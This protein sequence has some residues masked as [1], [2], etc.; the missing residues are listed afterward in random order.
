LTP[1]F[2]NM[3]K[4]VL[5]NQAGFL[6][7]AV[8]TFF[9]S[10]FVV[11][12]LG[13][14]RYGIWSL[15]V[16]LT[17]N[18]GLLAFGIQGAMTR[19]MAHAV[20]SG[21]RLRVNGYF[22]TSL[23]FLAV[24]SLLAVIVG[25]SVALFIDRVFVLPY[26]L[27]A[28]ARCACALATVSA[29]ATFLQAP[30]ESVLVAHQRF[31]V[32]NAIGVVIIMVRAALT[33]WLLKVGYGIVALALVGAGLTAASACMSAAIA[34]ASYRWLLLSLGSVRRVYLT[35]LMSYGG[36]SFVVAVAV[37]LVYQCDLF[38]IGANLPPVSITTYTLAATLFGYLIQ[39]VSAVMRTFTPHTTGLFS[40]GRM[41]ELRSFYVR[42][43]YSMF[44]FAGLVVAG[45]LLFGEAFFTLWVVRQYSASSQVLAL[46]VIAFFFDT[47]TRVG[48]AILSSTAEIGQLAVVAI[49]EGILNIALSIA[50]VGKYGYL[51]VAVGTLIPNVIC[52]GIWLPGYVCRT[53]GIGRAVPVLATACG[54]L[55]AAASYLAGTLML[56]MRYP[57]NWGIF[58]GEVAIFMAVFGAA[59]V[60][61]WRRRFVSFAAPVT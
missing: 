14:S 42:G 55:T 32:T 29:A 38:V 26:E 46:L 61:G 34:R 28:D 1:N 19:H 59:L 48:S 51:G 36:K 15:I 8:V 27:V 30:F 47:G 39:F 53:L 58:A 25:L 35:E 31:Q 45:C 60:I 7:S 18:Y 49:C 37:A 43:T 16:S 50:L 57:D 21:D 5:A 24:S 44:A 3:M 54:I 56:K 13:A 20:A 41:E 4:N 23:A 17:G 33:V 52:R 6:I 2:H 10:P 22:N 11:N 40:L 9:L 12:S